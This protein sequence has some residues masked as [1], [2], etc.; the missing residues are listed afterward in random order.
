M[1]RSGYIGAS[2]FRPKLNLS[3][4]HRAVTTGEEMARVP[5]DG[6]WERGVQTT[7]GVIALAAV[8]LTTAKLGLSLA[9]AHGNATPV[10]APSGI[11]LATLLLGGRRL[12][13]GILI[14]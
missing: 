1:M 14:G 2:P 4:A 10:W 7:V 6:R 5:R 13:P 8:Y 9:V 12:W 11:A 3:S